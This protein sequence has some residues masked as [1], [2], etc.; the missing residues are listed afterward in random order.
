MSRLKPVGPILSDEQV[1]KIRDIGKPDLSPVATTTKQDKPGRPNRHSSIVREAIKN[2]TVEFF[3][4]ILDDEN[5]AMFWRFFMTGNTD[6]LL[7]DPEGMALINP[8]CWAAFKRAVEYKRG[9]PVQSMPERPTSI[10]VHIHVGG[11][12][13]EFFREQ[14]K[15]M[16]YKVIEQ[17]PEAEKEQS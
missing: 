8:I 6:G 3:S 7:G 10:P 2:G 11:A 12:S 9:Q 1:G 16:G 4:S 17:L 14:A 15:A 5:E 13:P